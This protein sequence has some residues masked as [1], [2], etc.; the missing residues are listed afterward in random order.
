MN[1]Q[2]CLE[3][4]RIIGYNEDTPTLK[5]QYKRLKKSYIKLSAPARIIFLNKLKEDFEL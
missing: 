4:K 2:I 3:L 5:K 1:K